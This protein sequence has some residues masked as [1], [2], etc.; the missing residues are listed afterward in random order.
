LG[1]EHFSHRVQVGRK[2][3]KDGQPGTKAPIQTPIDEGKQQHEKGLISHESNGLKWQVE[4]GAELL[5]PNND[6]YAPVQ[7]TL[8]VFP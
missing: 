3:K 5:E 2:K 1:R 6:A 4:G 8:H 7:D